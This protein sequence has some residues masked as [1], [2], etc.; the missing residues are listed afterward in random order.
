M[1]VHSISPSQYTF[2]RKKV[3]ATVGVRSLSIEGVSVG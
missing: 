2:A 1:A 3:A